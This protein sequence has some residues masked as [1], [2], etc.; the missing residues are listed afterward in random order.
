MAKNVE[1]FGSAGA[2][3]AAAACPVCFP[4]LAAI[5]ALFGLGVLAP[6]EVF[7]LWGAQAMVLMICAIQYRSYKI[8]NNRFLLA[9]IIGFGGLFF[10]SLYAMPSELLSYVA[11]GGIVIGSIW[12]IFA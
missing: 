5:G 2:V 3:L 7:F 8:H 11:L 4:K 9:W 6:F 10:A 12:N 1:S